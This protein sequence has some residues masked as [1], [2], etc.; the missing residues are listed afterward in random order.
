MCLFATELFYH[1]TPQWT[2]R[3]S[4]FASCPYLWV[5]SSPN[6]WKWRYI[7]QNKDFI[8]LK[9]RFRQIKVLH[10]MLR[11]E[12]GNEDDSCMAAE[13]PWPSSPHRAQ[14]THNMWSS[15]AGLCSSRR[16]R[17]RADDNFND[18]IMLFFLIGGEGH[19]TSAGELLGQR[20]TSCPLDAV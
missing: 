1:V 18:A 8:F 20:L 14:L 16:F 10:W 7:C 6:T 9:P 17:L 15:S 3:S 2:T 12:R 5:A 11:D 19:V 13:K 4:T